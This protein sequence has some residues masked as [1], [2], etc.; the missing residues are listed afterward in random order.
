M[1]YVFVLDV[2]PA[3]LCP[4]WLT[5]QEMYMEKALYPKHPGIANVSLLETCS[6]INQEASQILYSRNIFRLSNTALAVTFFEKAL[7]N[8]ERC[9]WVKSIRLMLRPKPVQQRLPRSLMVSSAP[10]P[11]ERHCDH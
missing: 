2:S 6:F 11:L 4:Y 7:H 8:Y 5:E 3:K 10:T 1:I 9:S